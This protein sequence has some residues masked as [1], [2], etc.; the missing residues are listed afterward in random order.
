MSWEASGFVK[1]LLVCPDG[2]PLS[3]GQKLLML[4]LADY[5]D[6][7][8]KMAWPSVMT[9]AEESLSSHSQTK[10]DLAY[11]EEHQALVRARARDGA[12]GTYSYQFVGLDITLEDLRAKNK[13]VHGE[14]LFC[15]EERGSEEGHKGFTGALKRGSQGVHGE[16]RYKEEPEPKTKPEPEQHAASGVALKSNP[17]RDWLTIKNQL[18]KVLDDKEWRL[19]VRPAFLLKAMGTTDL[20][21]ALPPNNAIV[22]AAKARRELL[23]ELA[24]AVGYPGGVRLTPYPDEFT[25][26]RLRAEYPDFYQQMYGNKGVA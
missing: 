17:V 15:P 4:I 20:L 18:A 11:L 21:V 16:Q 8:R 24:A 9:L 1:K 10:R 22:M 7:R 26:E 25:K 3:R 6:P 5:H 14:P 12:G 23:R 2:A 19:W 13:G